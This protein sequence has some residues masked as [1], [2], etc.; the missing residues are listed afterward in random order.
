MNPREYYRKLSLEV[1]DAD[2]SKLLLA[3]V[4]HVGKENKIDRRSLVIKMYG[5][6]NE[7]L[8]RKMRMA[9]ALLT[10]MEFSFGKIA[11][12]SSSGE[13][14]YWIIRDESDREPCVAETGSR[15]AETD[16]VFENVSTGKTW[17]QL[18]GMS[19]REDE[20]TI[21][22]LQ[23]ALLE[24]PEPKMDYFYNWRR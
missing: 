4:D 24:V 20:P 2:A 22:F 7:S 15:K 18:C 11:I 23:P 21:E 13:G 16:A 19:E 10:K 12:G 17:E 9:K 5:K 3:L 14:G 6:Y 1:D 8:W